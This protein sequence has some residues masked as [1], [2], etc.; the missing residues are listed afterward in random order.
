MSSVTAHTVIIG[1]G[2]AGMAAALKLSA[3]GIDTL[4]LEA[5]AHTGGRACSENMTGAALPVE[6]GAEFIHGTPPATLELLRACGIARVDTADE[7]WS[8]TSGEFARETGDYEAETHL[9]RRALAAL[10]P[11]QDE[12]I[13]AALRRIAAPEDAPVQASVLGMVR[14]FDAA[15]P[16]RASVRAVAAEWAG[17]AS[18]ATASARIIGGYSELW[19]ALTARILAQRAA[20][21][22]RCIVD[23]IRYGP[24]NVQLTA[25]TLTGDTLEITAQYA[26]VTLPLGVLKTPGDSENRV[27][28]QP[29]LPQA[30]TAALDGL[31]SGPVIK[32]ILRFRT[33]FWET[34]EGGKFRNGAFFRTPRHAPYPVLWTT[35]PLRSCVLT[36]WAGGS[37][38]KAPL[39][40][41]E[42]A[43]VEAAL[44]TIGDTFGAAAGRIA[45]DELVAARM[46]DWQADPFARGAYSYVATGGGDARRILHEPIAGR[47]FLAGEAY[48]ENG[49]GGT[50]AGALIS[51]ANAA[52]RILAVSRRSQSLHDA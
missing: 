17:D 4:L 45:R 21:R 18:L 32:T 35:L 30:V 36:A 7:T 5:R 8:Y 41:G 51:G 40:R 47:I 19:R 2:A 11:D 39:T 49:E 46:H 3:A 12:S 50:V 16:E 1:A 52:D 14:G 27:R 15:D 38:V 13:A 48:A 29:P 37:D 20:I 44:S 24:E 33:A 26:I 42:S 28:W 25:S 23:A 6:L 22:T 31:E 9:L 43:A 34:I 10:P